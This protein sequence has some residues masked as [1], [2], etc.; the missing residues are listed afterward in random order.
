MK[1]RKKLGF[2]VPEELWARWEPLIPAHANPHPLGGGRPRRP[3]RDCANAIFFVLRTGCQWEALDATGLCPHSTAHDRFQEWVAGGLWPRLWQEAVARYD[4][5][6]GLDW[7]FLCADG[8]MT[9][10]PLAREECGPNP[11]DRG[12][13]GVKRSLLTEAH[14]IPLS[15]VVAGANVND[16]QLLDQTLCQ[17]IAPRPIPSPEHPQGLCLDKGYDYAQTRQ[18]GVAHRLELHLRTRGEEKTADWRQPGWKPRRWVVE[19]TGSWLNRFRRLLVRWEKKTANY[20]GML[21]LA[22]ACITFQQAGLFG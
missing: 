6:K 21:G 12:K 1:R 19:R 5:L 7:S 2:I 18:I 22:C 4:E 14:G 11:T 17:V 16:H 10:A 9:K 15:V 3:D 20:S 13:Q 8:S